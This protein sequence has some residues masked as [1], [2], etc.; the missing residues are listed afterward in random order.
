MADD[1]FKDVV[2]RDP[3]W[4]FRT[5]DVSKEFD[6]AMKVDNG[7]LTASSTDIKTFIGRGGKLVMYHGWADQNISSRSSVNYYT[8][9]VTDLGQK[10]VEDSVRL[11]VVPGMGH[12]GGGDGPNQ[13]DMLTKLEQWREQ[14][15]PPKRSSRRN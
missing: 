1:L 11:Y 4:D 3:N 12:C 5:T 13:F 15:R 2:F 14:G 6:S 10:Q 8:R 9:L 7:V